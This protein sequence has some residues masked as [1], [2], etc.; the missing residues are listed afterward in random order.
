MSQMQAA[1]IRGCERFYASLEPK[2][3]GS[4]IKFFE[5]KVSTI[6]GKYGIKEEQFINQ[7][8][9]LLV[10]PYSKERFPTKEELSSYPQDI[11]KAVVD[12]LRDVEH[13]AILQL[14][15]KYIP[16]MKE[17]EKIISSGQKLVLWIGG[18]LV[19]LRCIFPAK[20]SFSKVDVSVTVLHMIGIGVLSTVSFFTL[21]NVNLRN[22]MITTYKAVALTLK[23]IKEPLSF[24]N[25]WSVLF[26]LA[27]VG[28]VVRYC[29]KIE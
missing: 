17:K 8:F 2:V 10:F 14:V 24:L 26:L 9:D 13:H 22:M 19:F 3:A 12:Y 5:G 23:K 29:A 20:I 7:F 25:I 27:M 21:K 16:E 18:L 11:R 15:G 1:I 4:T 28:H 6:L